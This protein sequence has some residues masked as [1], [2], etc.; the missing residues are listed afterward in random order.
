MKKAVRNLDIENDVEVE[1]R[2]ATG[3]AD[4]VDLFSREQKI[5]LANDTSFGTGYAPMSDLEKVVL[6]TELHHNSTNYKTKHPEI[7]EDI[8][9]MGLRDGNKLK[10]TIA[11]AFN[12]RFVHSVDE[13]KKL[14]ERV[15]KDA[16]E[17]AKRTTPLDIEI[18][19]NT[20]DDEKNGSVYITLTGTSAEMGDDGA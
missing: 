9:V 8:K 2:I 18:F 16:V 1:S 5:P 12:S 17:V 19:V 14:K 15:A 20:A 6:Q 10:V 7:G 13:Y 4:L 3:S 11:V